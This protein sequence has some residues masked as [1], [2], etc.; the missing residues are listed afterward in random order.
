[1]VLGLL[2]AN[3][4][5]H[6]YRVRAVAERSQA[7]GWG[8]I[9]LGSLHRELRTME[10]AGLVHPVRSESVANRPA[11]TVY[12]IT[13]E[14]REALRALRE[15]AVSEPSEGP[16]RLGVALMFGR[17][18]D[19]DELAKL[20]ETRRATITAHLAYTEVEREQLVADGLITPFDAA[21]F[22]R[23]A[24]RMEAE[25]RWL[26]EWGLQ[27]GSLPQTLTPGDSNDISDSPAAEEK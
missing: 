15:Q 8:G 27:L 10:G 13:G 1:M 18:G 24:M 23:H 9:S 7:E 14:G 12:E 20:L 25:L 22:R 16:D 4:P 17:L 2:D 19:W 21:I 5:M 26:E 11:R 6:G 3:G